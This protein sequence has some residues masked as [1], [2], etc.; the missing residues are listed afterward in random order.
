VARLHFQRQ[1]APADHRRRERCCARWVTVQARQQ[2]AHRAERL[3]VSVPSHCPLLHGELGI[4]GAAA[5]IANAVYHAAV[6]PI[7]AAIA[8]IS[9]RNAGLRKEVSK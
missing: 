6:K 5:V 4:V 8:R 1:C 9:F 3:A 2:G 7:V